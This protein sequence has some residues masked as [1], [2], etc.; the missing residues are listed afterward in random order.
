MNE[1]QEEQ[2]KRIEPQIQACF[3]VIKASF[4]ILAKEGFPGDVVVYAA[5]DAAA[6]LAVEQLGAGE[7]ILFLRERADRIEQGLDRPR[8]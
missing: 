8:G 2:R 4:S 6:Q 5:L 1:H 3:K 7:A